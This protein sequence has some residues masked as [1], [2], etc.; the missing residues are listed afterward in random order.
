MLDDPHRPTCCG[1]PCQRR[2]LRPDGSA[3]YHCGT[4]GRSPGAGMLEDPDRPTCCGRPCHRHEVHE[5]RVRYR[6]PVCGAVTGLGG[7]AMRSDRPPRCPRCQAR[8]QW[9]GAGRAACVG[10]VRHTYTV[11]G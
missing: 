11:R 10:P 7:Y 2:A 1:R 9:H 5:D 6:C 4:C 3:R 8:A